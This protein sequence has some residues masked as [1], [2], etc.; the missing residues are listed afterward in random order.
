MK[1]WMM[2]VLGGGCVFFMTL[3]SIGCDSSVVK[4]LVL[5]Q[6]VNFASSIT[7]AVITSL[8][9]SALGTTSAS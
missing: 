4:P 2:N 6:L 9:Q 5:T 3:S 8:I 1:K 7:S